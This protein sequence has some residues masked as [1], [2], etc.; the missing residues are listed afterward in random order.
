M[1]RD[2]FASAPVVALGLVL[3]APGFVV[4]APA[5][6]FLACDRTIR[7]VHRTLTQ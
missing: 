6:I 3:F 5:W 1:N 4:T 2:T 7:K